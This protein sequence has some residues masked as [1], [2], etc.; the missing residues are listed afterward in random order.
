MPGKALA[1]FI[2]LHHQTALTRR[3][4]VKLPSALLVELGVDK[5]TKARA[6]RQLEAAGL[7]SVRRQTG[8]SPLIELR[9]MDTKAE[10]SA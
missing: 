3:A 5:D 1:V 7:I 10:S 6:M 4:A 9:S 8:R 2:A